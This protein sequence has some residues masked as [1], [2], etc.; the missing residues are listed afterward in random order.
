MTY[1]VEEVTSYILHDPDGDYYPDSFEDVED[2]IKKCKEVEGD[3]Y[4]PQC[5]FN[6]MK[7]CE[8]CDWCD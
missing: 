6:L 5:V 1:K 8:K 4:I 2:A 7:P 3:D